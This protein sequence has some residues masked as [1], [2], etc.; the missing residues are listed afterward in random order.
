MST[1][2]SF[3]SIGIIALILY[4]LSFT[5]SRIGLIRTVTHRKIWNVL[6]G[7]TFFG[8]ALLGIIMAIRINY[9]LDIPWVD[10]ITILHVDFGISMVMIAMFHF[11]WHIKYYADIFRG[12]KYKA[13]EQDGLEYRDNSGFAVAGT[14]GLSISLTVLG[15][16]SLVT[17][18]IIIR[19]FLSVFQ[20]NELVIGIILANWMFITGIGSY[21]GKYSNRIKE[22][23]R[24]SFIA[25]IAMGVLPFITVFLLNYLKNIVFLPGSLVGV[26]EIF[27]GSFILLLPFCL[28]SGFLFTFLAAELSFVHKSKRIDI[29]Y[30][31][32]SFGSLIGGILFS[33]ILVFLMTPFQ[34]LT[35]LL[36][37]NLFVAVWVNLRY[38][39]VM[40]IIAFSVIVVL[41]SGL[42]FFSRFDRFV[43]GFMYPNQEIVYLK[44]T[45]YGNLAVTKIGEQ[46][47]FYE[48]QVL[49]FNTLN[50]IANEEAV[51]YAMVQH[52]N[53]QN[54]LVISGGV[55]GIIHEIMKYPVRKVDYLEINPWLVKIGE[56]FYEKLEDSRIQIYNKDARLFLK[57]N[58]GPYDIVLVNLPAPSTTNLNRYYTIEF[59]HQL[60]SCMS[61][62]GVVSMDLPS[63]GNYAGEEANIVNSLIF[64]TLKKVFANVIM[65]PGEKNFYLASNNTVGF[66]IT[67]RIEE[68]NIENQY[69]N[70][71]Y[72]D[73]T[74]IRNRSNFFMAQLDKNAG[75]NR[76]FEPSAYFHQI[77]SWLSY[78]QLNMWVFGGVVFLVMIILM[79]RLNTVQVGIFAG[80]F[81]ASSSE[82]ILI[83]AFQIIY[84]Y[85]YLMTGIIIAVFMGGMTLGAVIGRKIIKTPGPFSFSGNQLAIGLFALLLPL[86]INIAKPITDHQYIV[87]SLFFILTLVISFLV[88]SL[89]SMASRIQ[90]GHVSAVTAGIYS[91]DLAGS[92]FGA[93]IVSAFL[94]PL[95]GLAKVSIV[96]GLFNILFAGI[97]WVNRKRL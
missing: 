70:K 95:I 26:L 16:T 17:Q 68:K 94:I 69:V 27:S 67:G 74:L 22:P 62:D 81:A 34:I 63:T 65:I 21:L 49:L 79:I 8:T 6:L 40:V 32:E 1:P 82:V 31:L 29:A 51:H 9:K 97:T 28:L 4:L 7:L 59:F 58:H 75:I 48:N 88:G 36:V 18:I 47:N 96:V 72:L 20:G 3:I 77:S 60:E 42:T 13:E 66:D 61:P 91:A 35:I 80:G 76:D 44:E 83:I 93:L 24:I 38:Q 33:F 50:F 84:G 89:F 5:I 90:K 10:Q 37:L 41:V 23:V 57:D 56:K 86:L 19:E 25:Q 12:K 11:S 78:Y 55:S 2:Y 71:Y 64:N 53:P 39:K 73:D 45:P 14:R 54:I 43:K 30:A 46:Y 85:V 15:I 87:H 92:A 52:R